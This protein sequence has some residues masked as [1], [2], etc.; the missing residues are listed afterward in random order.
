MDYNNII[1]KH[2]NAL[3]KQLFILKEAREKD[4]LIIQELLQTVS[5]KKHENESLQNVISTLLQM[6]NDNDIII[7]NLS[8]EKNVIG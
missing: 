8:K 1:V 5:L 3:S 7:N 2:N 6:L 4:F